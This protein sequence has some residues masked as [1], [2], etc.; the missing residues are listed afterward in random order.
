M[1]IHGYVLGARTAQ[2]DFY[3]A[4]VRAPSPTHY[5]HTEKSRARPSFKPFN[6]SDKRFK[7]AFSGSNP[8]PG[9]YEHAVQRNRNVQMLHTFGGRTKSVPH[10]DVKCTIYNTLKVDTRLYSLPRFDFQFN[11]F[12]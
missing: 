3:S 9:A 5:Q 12:S 1:S 11:Q 8:G 6:Q 10:V 7:S 2:R 4:V